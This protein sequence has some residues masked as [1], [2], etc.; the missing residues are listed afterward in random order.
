MFFRDVVQDAMWGEL[1]PPPD[2]VAVHQHARGDVGQLPVSVDQVGQD[3]VVPLPVEWPGA[4]PVP[5]AHGEEVAVEGG[6]EPV[7]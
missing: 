1:E 2:A 7:S 4:V 5:G 6:A 3:A